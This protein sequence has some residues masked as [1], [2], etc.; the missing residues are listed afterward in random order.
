MDKENQLSH[1]AIKFLNGKCKVV[2]D[3]TTLDVDYIFQIFNIYMF[4]ENNKEYSYSCALFDDE[5]ICNNFVLKYNIK[6]RKLYKKDIISISKITIKFLPD[7]EHFLYICS[8][9]KLLKKSPYFLF[10]PTNLIKLSTKIKNSSEKDGKNDIGKIKIITINFNGKKRNRETNNKFEKFLGIN[11]EFFIDL[12][13]KEISDITKIFILLFINEENSLMNENKKNRNYEKFFLINKNLEEEYKT[14]FNSIKKL[15]KNNLESI[16]EDVHK[17]NNNNLSCDTKYIDNIIS[18][19]DESLLTK[20]DK[21]IKE[22]EKNLYITLNPDIETISLIDKQIRLYK[23]YILLNENIFNYINKI[24]KKSMNKYFIYYFSKRDREIELYEKD[25]Q[26]IIIFRSHTNNKVYIFDYYSHNK[27]IEAKNEL[28]DCNIK[29]YIKNKAV[30]NYD[31]ISPIFLK[32]HI[33]GYCYIYTPNTDYTSLINYYDYLSNENILNCINIY[34]N[35]Q[36]I[37]NKLEQ[38]EKKVGKEKYFL[39]HKDYLNSLKDEYNFSILDEKLKDNKISETDDN[40]NKKILYM[41]KT[42]TKYD[43]KKI[44]KKVKMK[45]SQNIAPDITTFYYFDKSKKSIFLYNNFELIQDNIIKKLN[46]IENINNYECI[47]ECIINEG[48]IILNYNYSLNNDVYVSVLGKLDDENI[49][50]TEYILIYKSKIEQNKH[51]NEISSNLINFIKG[52]QLYNNSQPIVDNNYKEVGIILKNNISYIKNNFNKA[53]NIGLENI[54]ATCYMNATLQCFCHI[55]KFVN[56]FKSS[57]QIIDIYKNK[58]ETLSYSFKLLIDELWPSNFNNSKYRKKYYAP[59]EFKKKISKMNPLFEGIAAND[60]KDLVNFIVMTLHQELNKVKENNNEA[61]IANTDI[62]IDQ[63]NKQLM[64]NNFA[65]F[66]M[67]NNQSIISDLFYAMN[68]TI[69]ECFSCH[70]RLYN[71]QIY[72]FIIFPLEEVRKFKYSNTFNMFNNFNVVSIYDCFDYDKKMNIMSG[73]NSIYCNFCKIN[74]SASMTNYLCTG[75]EILILL[76]NRGK[77]IEFNVKL[78][79]DEKLNLYNYIELK[80]TGFNYS[81]IGVITH[82]GESSM[83]GHFIAY[84]KEPINNK[85]FK[86]NDSI[87][88][89]V[90]DFYKEVINFAMPYLLFFQKIK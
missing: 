10:D 33:I 87:V 1:G 58:K 61:N 74:Y 71:Y 86:Y 35:Y 55:E 37:Y 79:F 49:F 63:T 38:K 62:R 44:T 2:N 12:M 6:D 39:V 80:E 20:I 16:I 77:G 27:Y 18:K 57:K 15:M 56:F 25:S 19:L 50:I 60:A 28:L 64:F 65:T 75:P 68:Y 17:I 3:K 69:T 53:P 90:N 7:K 41:I 40:Y 89:E 8:G 45:N 66:F 52:L 24:Y 54:G 78:N 34:F 42:L 29:N 21:K 84:C 26:K 43:L 31:Q 59:Q 83:N 23:D 14:E 13:D 51:I 82:I 22:K 67:N 85:W 9:I 32:N 70:T 11:D 48:K 72:F 47:A 30:F 88:T 46:I 73:A 36:R 76:L 4:T 5:N 81:L